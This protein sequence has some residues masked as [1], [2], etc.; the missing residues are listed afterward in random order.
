M[1]PLDVIVET[2]RREYRGWHPPVPRDAHIPDSF[3]LKD[4]TPPFSESE[5]PRSPLYK[6]IKDEFTGE[7]LLVPVDYKE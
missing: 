4:R 6:T 1:W 7:D 2:I 3:Y 5:N